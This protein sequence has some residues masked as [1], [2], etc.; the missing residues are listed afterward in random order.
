[1]NQSLRNAPSIPTAYFPKR[2][3]KAKTTPNL[4]R[5]SKTN[6]LADILNDDN[7]LMLTIDEFY[8]FL[9]EIDKKITIFHSVYI[10]FPF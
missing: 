7:F 3:H 4:V 8:I 1:M 5:L 9:Y 6:I 10:Q 2:E